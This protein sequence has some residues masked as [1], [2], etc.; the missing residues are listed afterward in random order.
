LLDNLWT[1][2]QVDRLLLKQALPDGSNVLITTREIERVG[3]Y[4]QRGTL[5]STSYDSQDLPETY[6][7]P[8]MSDTA[9]KL[10]LH[11]RTMG[12]KV[13]EDLFTVCA[14]HFGIVCL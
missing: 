6:D 14:C 7:M 3:E 5:R 4:A 1:S 11:K 2:G 12:I 9:A 10:L 13:T 8:A